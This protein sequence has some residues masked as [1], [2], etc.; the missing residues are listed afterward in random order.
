MLCAVV[1][2]RVDK[3]VAARAKP[4]QHNIAPIEETLIFNNYSYI[5][6]GTF[7]GTYDNGNGMRMWF[8]LH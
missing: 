8:Q 7:K 4:K 6:S 2:E 5:V 1:V 3:V